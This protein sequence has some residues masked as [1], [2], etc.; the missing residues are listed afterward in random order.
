MPAAGPRV[1][2][3][4]L[5]TARGSCPGTEGA[6][7][8]GDGA[9]VRGGP[10]I[11]AGANADAGRA[12]SRSRAPPDI[13]AEG[14]AAAFVRTWLS[15]GHS[16]RPTAGRLAARDA[17]IAV[18]ARGQ[19]QAIGW[20]APVGDACTRASER[21]IVIAAASAAAVW[22]VAVPITRT[23]Q[24]LVVS[25]PPGDRGSA[26][27]RQHRADATRNRGHRPEPCGDGHTGPAALPSPRH[28]RP[29]P[30]TW[31]REPKSRCPTSR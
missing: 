6:G 29:Q 24:G 18:D 4:S 31:R 25:G 23:A 17:D 12:E 11:D 3:V 10:S 7:E 9:A 14:I 13:Q 28:R 26:E 8:R 20:T 21:R 30:P 22:H 2:S 16:T 19:S 1:D 27:S 5:A 15:W